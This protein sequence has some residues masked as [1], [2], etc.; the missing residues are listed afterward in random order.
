VKADSRQIERYRSDGF[1]VIPDVFEPA[2]LERHGRAVDAAVAER[3]SADT[4]P[5]ADKSLYEQSFLQCMNLWETSRAVRS[6][7]FDAEVGE[8]AASLMEAERLRIWHDQALYKEPGGRIT[9]PHQDLPFW[10][11]YPP[12]QITAWIPFDGSVRECG[13]MSY[14]PGSH[15]VGIKRFVDITHS[16][17][18]LDI[19]ADPAIA[20]VEPV[21]VEAP[22]GSVV[23]HHSLTV[24]GAEPNVT[25]RTR[26]VYC[27]IWLA[28][29]CQRSK[30]WP[31]VIVDRQGNDVG[32]LVQ[33]DVTPIAW[34]LQDGTPPHPP[35]SAPPQ[36]GFTT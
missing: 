23:F 5:M 6:L 14:V 32:E 25:D 11:I 10:P 35:T 29:G 12:N 34:P 24:H 22:L 13:A 2:A 7:T 33:G 19:L 3:T 17:E 15:A 18:P 36:T 8:L 28:D 20:D 4:R 9:D 1:V 31:H 21:L 16:T 30:P 26:R 27:V